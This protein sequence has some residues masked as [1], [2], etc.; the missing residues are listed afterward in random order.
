MNTEAI[1][2]TAAI[3]ETQAIKEIVKEKYGQA[4]VRAATGG[5][6]CCGTAAGGCYC[7]PACCS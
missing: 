4:A 7:G 5:N 6:S 1:R 2:E 3:K